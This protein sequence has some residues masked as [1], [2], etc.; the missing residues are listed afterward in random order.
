MDPGASGWPGLGWAASVSSIPGVLEPSSSLVLVG[1][2][3]QN[4]QTWAYSK[5][6][7]PMEEASSQAS[8]VLITRAR[9]SR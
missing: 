7:E 8:G 2:P 4:V 1:E 3:L 6:A 9:P 5:S